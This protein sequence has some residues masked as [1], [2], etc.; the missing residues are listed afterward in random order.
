VPDIVA[1]ITSQ[2]RL[3]DDLLEQAQQEDSDTLDL[4]RQVYELLR[5]H[6]EAEES[7]VYPRI[8]ELDTEEAEEVTDGAAEHHHVEQLLDE[9]L[10]GDPDEPGYD[11][12]L[13]AVVGELRHHV[14]EEEEELLPVLTE[15]ATAE[16]REQLGAR[17]AVATGHD[18]IVLDDDA[19]VVQTVGTVDPDEATRDELYAQAK[20]LEV[21][22][23]SGMNKS[24]LAAAISAEEA[25]QEVPTTNA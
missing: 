18:E 23:R 4:L 16:E 13:A 14:Q 8:R 15:K 11:G 9:L 10:A 25:A 6:S 20:K 19:A 12:K 24:E 5:P 7:F 17:F 22:G 3:I 1:V 2:H 21:P